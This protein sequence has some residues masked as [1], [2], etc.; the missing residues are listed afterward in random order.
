VRALISRPKFLS[1]DA[2]FSELKSSGNLHLIKDIN[3]NWLLFSYYS[4]AENIKENQE[5][6]Q[7]AT[8]E[9][10]G[11]YFLQLFS[12]DGSE[13]SPVFRNPGGIKALAA[14]AEFRNHVLARVGT[15]QELQTLYK[16]TDSLASQLLGILRPGN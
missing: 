1:H 4:K 14:N 13:K 11:R 5:A 3:L 16:D 7:L 10:S 2:T 12:M 15:R 8:I 6:E 9:L